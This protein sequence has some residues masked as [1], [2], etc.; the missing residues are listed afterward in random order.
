MYV[1]TIITYKIDGA[2]WHLLEN[3]IIRQ[4]PYLKLPRVV[5]HLGLWAYLEVGQVLASYG[6]EIW[7]NI[8]G[9]MLLDYIESTWGNIHKLELS[10]INKELSLYIKY[11]NDGLLIYFGHCELTH[12]QYVSE[13][14]WFDKL[15]LH[16]FS[17]FHFGK[18]PLWGVTPYSMF[19]NEIINESK[20]WRQWGVWIMRIRLGQLGRDLLGHVLIHWFKFWSLTLINCKF[21]WTIN[22]KILNC[23]SEFHTQKRLPKNYS[24][25]LW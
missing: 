18:P 4:I 16:M 13:S 8:Y 17:L 10:T 23:C 11:C 3:H 2:F 1:I 21:D 19:Q 7:N 9:W 24:H 12:F 22:I 15:Q 5:S 14:C 25:Y 20:A 6:I